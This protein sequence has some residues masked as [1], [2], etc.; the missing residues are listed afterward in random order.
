MVQRDVIGTDGTGRDG[1]GTDGIE[2]NSIETHND[3]NDMDGNAKDDAMDRF[4]LA[5]DSIGVKFMQ[6]E[7]IICSLENA[8]YVVEVS[9]SEQYK[10]KG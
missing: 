6:V 1:T 2:E 8:E 7:N 9:L 5:K 4:D 3:M 10:P